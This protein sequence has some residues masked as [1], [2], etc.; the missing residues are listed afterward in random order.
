[1]AE[2]GEAPHRSGAIA[3]VLRRTLR[4]VAPIRARLIARGTLYSRSHGE[5]A[6]TVPL[7]HDYLRRIMP[8]SV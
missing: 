3:K 2:L 1:M 5:T 6:F 4:S 7:F 8:P